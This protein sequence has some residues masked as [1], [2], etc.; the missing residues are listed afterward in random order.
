MLEKLKLE[1]LVIKISLEAE[2]LG[3]KYTLLLDMLK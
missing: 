2:K 1:I 3:K